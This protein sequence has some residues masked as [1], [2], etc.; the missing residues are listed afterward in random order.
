[1]ALIL[2][3][4]ESNCKMQHAYSYL[5]QHVMSEVDQK[6]HCQLV[7]LTACRISNSIFA[8]V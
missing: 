8:G 7:F 4:H 5:D 3:A 1:M 2:T 6:A